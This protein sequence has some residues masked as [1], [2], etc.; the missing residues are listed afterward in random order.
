M[1]QLI[2]LCQSLKPLTVRG[3]APRVLK[4]CPRY[5]QSPFYTSANSLYPANLTST[6][7]SRKPKHG[8][9]MAAVIYE[10]GGP[11]VLKIEKRQIP[12]P[13]SDQ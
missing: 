4:Y 8:T 6:M 11:E 2:Y 10:A 12:K 1:S 5:S 13:V 3:L 9:M 7:T